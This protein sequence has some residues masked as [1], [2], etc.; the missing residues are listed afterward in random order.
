VS[1]WKVLLGVERHVV[2]EDIELEVTGDG[3]SVVVAC[4]RP[5]KRR[6]SRCGLRLR[7][8]PG[9]DQGEGPRR[10]Q[11]L[12]LGSTRVFLEAGAPRVRCREHGVVVAAVGWA[13]HD[14]RFTAAFEDP[15]G[16]AGRARDGEHGGGAD[17][18]V[19]AGGDGDGGP[20]G[21]RGPRA[22]RPAR[23]GGQGR[24]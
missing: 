4:V 22:E 3:E 2:I 6:S 10:W 14:S 9:Y 17:A 23:R 18:L 7:R 16:L 11:G 19:L 5:A 15:G 8:C 12:D 24:D 1:P 20:G 21:G 13:R